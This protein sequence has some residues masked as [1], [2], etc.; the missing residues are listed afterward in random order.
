M[1][2][3]WRSERPE[4]TGGVHAATG[5]MS[6]VGEDT[7]AGCRSRLTAWLPASGL[8]PQACRAY[9]GGRCANQEP[10]D[11]WAD[12]VSAFRRSELAPTGGMP[13]GRTRPASGTRWLRRPMRGWACS[14]PR[15][16]TTPAGRTPA[17]RW[18]S[19]WSHTGRSAGVPSALAHLQVRAGPPWS[20]C[21]GRGGNAERNRCPGGARLAAETIT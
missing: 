18:T 3:R 9:C 10:D 12:Q 8:A 21:A 14:T 2:D 7:S 15:R 4:S 11:R 16:L 6:W 5:R 19:H 20:A 13:A 17:A 1:R